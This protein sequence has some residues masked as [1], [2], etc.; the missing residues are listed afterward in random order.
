MISFPITN[1]LI[2]PGDSVMTVV[3]ILCVALRT[4]PDH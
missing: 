1:I 2:E 4:Y 3:V